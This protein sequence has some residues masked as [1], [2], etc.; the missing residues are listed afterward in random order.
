MGAETLG[1]RFCVPSALVCPFSVENEEYQYRSFAA[2]HPLTNR[3]PEGG[4]P[5]YTRTVG[6]IRTCAFGDPSDSKPRMVPLY[7]GSS[8]LSLSLSLS[9]GLFKLPPLYFRMTRSHVSM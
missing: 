1:G 8:S 5:T 4:S 6:R 2:A 7:H 9:I 3:C